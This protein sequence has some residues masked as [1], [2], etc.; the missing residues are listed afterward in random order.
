[1]AITAPC[2]V[3]KVTVTA[4][5]GM[6]R[7]NHAGF[8]TT[9]YGYFTF[10]ALP[11]QAGYKYLVQFYNTSGAAV[12]VAVD[13]S[14]YTHH[15]HGIGSANWTVYSIPLSAFGSIGTV[16]GVSIKDN[17]GAASNTFYLSAVGFWGSPASG[18]R[19]APGHYAHSRFGYHFDTQTVFD[20]IIS[21]LQTL[22]VPFRGVSIN[23]YYGNFDRGTSSAD[24]SQGITN[25][26]T[27]LDAALAAGKFVG[28]HFSEQNF[29][30]S[31]FP[32]SPTYPTWWNSGWCKT[33]SVPQIYADLTQTAVVNTITA[34]IQAYGAAFKD[35]P[36]LAW[37]SP[38]DDSSIS[39]TNFDGTTYYANRVSLFQVARNAFPRTMIRGYW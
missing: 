18:F 14:S 10:S 4:A 9:L 26:R 29:T 35:H 36:A 30:S 6:W 17:S 19:F 8:N 20:G 1:M 32:N 2:P 33:G 25:V 31:A 11:T 12:G 27:E 28:L 13:P 38:F 24:F 34:Q 5:G 3:A 37:F 21:D 7:C 16:G 39:T 15:D 22:P 23:A